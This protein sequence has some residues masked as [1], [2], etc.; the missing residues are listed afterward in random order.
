MSNQCHGRSLNRPG[1]NRPTI[2]KKKKK[3]EPFSFLFFLF[4]FYLFIRS[5][6]RNRMNISI[7]IF[8]LKIRYMIEINRRSN[9]LSDRLPSFSSSFI[10]PTPPPELKP[11]ELA[12]SKTP[13]IYVNDP[14]NV[15]T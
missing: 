14:S 5:L 13:R 4:F 2:K 11:L 1:I 7:E 6:S 8:Q 12:S 10:P 3:N 9:I 15:F